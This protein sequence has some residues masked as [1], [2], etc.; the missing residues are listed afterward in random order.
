MTF[1]KP[2]HI[3]SLWCGP[4]TGKDRGWNWQMKSKSGVC[5]RW[6][7]IY[8]NILSRVRPTLS[9]SHC[10]LW[11]TAALQSFRHTF[12][13]IPATSEPLTGG[14][15]GEQTTIFPTEGHV[16]AQERWIWCGSGKEL[17]NTWLFSKR[18]E[19]CFISNEEGRFRIEAHKEEAGIV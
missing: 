17:L 11:L 14:A 6:Q 3:I 4:H 5:L 10:V 8:E 13:T 16:E 18:G 2:L 1:C 19:R 7:W 15:R 12:G 9:C